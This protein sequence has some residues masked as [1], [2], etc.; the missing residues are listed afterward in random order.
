MSARLPRWVLVLLLA[1][2]LGAVPHAQP[3]ARDATRTRTSSASAATDPDFAARVREW[4]TGPEFLS[5]LV[6]HL[7][8]VKGIPTPK[9]VLGYHVGTP[10]RLTKTADALAY[11]RALE[12]ASPRIR[13]TTIGR[14]DEGREVNVVYVASESTMKQLDTHIASLGRLADPRGLSED[15]ARR[16][17]AS[18]PPIYHLMAG[19]HSAETG[20]PEM[21]MELAYRLVAEDTPLIRQI[22]DRI[23]VSFT[24]ASDPDGR[25]RYVD[26]YRKY[27]V[28]ITEEKDRITGPPYWGKYIFHDNNRDIN[29]SQV[30][31]RAHLEW[32]LKTHP[33]V[34][35]DLHESVPFLYTFSG[36]APQNPNLDPIVYGELPMFANFE[37]MQL[38]RYGMP[39]VWTHG[40]VD[41]WSPGYL[42]FM[43]SNHNGLV[44]MYETFGN[45]GATTMKRRVAPPDGGAGQTS[46]EWYRPLPPYK[47]VTWSMR[48]NTNYMQT[49]VLS[50]LQYASAFPE[51]LVENF[52]RKSRNSLEAGRTEAP[53]AYIVPA[54]QPDQTRVDTLLFLLMRQGIEISRATADVKVADTVYPA[55]SY[56]I[57]R[58]QPYGRLVKTLLEKQ[59][60]PDPS[61]RTYDDTGWTMGLMLQVDV[62]PIADK[63]VLE[64]PA[65]PVTDLARKGTVSGPAA[66][67]A[68]VVPHH[69]SNDMVRLRLALGRTV[70]VRATSAG[71][72]VGDVRYPA[73]SFIVP[74]SAGAA[75]TDAVTSL[76][77]AATGLATMPD[78]A[79]VAV[80]LPRLAMFSTWGR[81]QEVGWVRHAFDTFGI[82]YDLIYKERVRQGSL[83]QAYDVILVPNQ[84]TTGKSLVYD[85]ERK[86]GPLAYRKDPQFPT[87]GQYGESDDITGGMGL[88]GV[89]QLQ[90]FVEDGGV[91]VTLGA[92]SYMPA[93]FGLQRTVTATR[94]TAAFY[95]PGPIVEV[96]VLRPEHPIFFG[97]AKTRLPVRYANGPLLQVPTEDVAEQVLMRFTGGDEGVLSGLMRGSAEIRRRPALV[98]TPMGQGRVV[99]FATN[100]CYRWQN[101]G[102]FGMLF[103]AAVLFWNDVPAK[104]AKEASTVTAAQ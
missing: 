102:E 38:T 28:D 87:L 53:Y 93:E 80:D 45:G 79:T 10:K 8:L 11:Y 75:L 54:G 59:T 65:S 81:T 73:G 1:L 86:G 30:T 100:P 31:L 85:V 33:P 47:E 34:M 14:T 19:L 82:P 66:P 96:E 44:R 91:L 17:V 49:A 68:W 29:Y 23:I 20:P 99:A 94:P 3:A 15:E 77:L 27:M 60:F 52:Y 22:R 56:V 92:S 72:S 76:G 21:L 67:A 57:R 71:F 88:E 101:H 69:G 25:D 55:G 32:Y 62:K 58:D 97:Y 13:V 7:P 64:A 51:V 95:A 36:Q 35:H 90:K 9:D 74:A 40:F 4:T 70:D 39:G 78:V 42:A 83:R 18:T 48:N 63:A 98:D 104:K 6:D 12:K 50:A 43:S 89:V 37:M 41:M 16:L 2:P 46:R 26:W 24:P 61:L 5:P 103:N 84:A